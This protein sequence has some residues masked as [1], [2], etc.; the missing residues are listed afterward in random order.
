MQYFSD[1]T[2][3]GSQ[4]TYDFCPYFQGASNGD[5]DTPANA[6][7]SNFRA[8]MY[9]VGSRCVESTLSQTVNSFVLSSP[10]TP[11]P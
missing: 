1:P 10:N 11:N 9:G 8:E 7:T 2:I 4:A 5:C 3:G 6:P